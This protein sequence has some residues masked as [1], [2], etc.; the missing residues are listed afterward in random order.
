MP[1]SDIDDAEKHNKIDTIGGNLKIEIKK[2]VKGNGHQA[3]QC[4]DGHKKPKRII[5]QFDLF[6]PAEASYQKYIKPAYQG[7]KA[8]PAGFDQQLQIVVVGVMG[9]CL[10]DSGHIVNRKHLLKRC[11]AGTKGV[12]LNNHQTGVHTIII[13]IPPVFVIGYLMQILNALPCL[14]W[15]FRLTSYDQL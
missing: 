1:K 12:I 7:N 8:D 2:A 15:H 14:L 13:G 5:L 4:P 3:A 9:R 10:S 6:N 11:Q